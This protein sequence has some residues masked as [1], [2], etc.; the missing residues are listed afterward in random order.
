MISKVTILTVYCAIKVMLKSWRLTFRSDSYTKATTSKSHC[1]FEST[2][3]S[4]LNLY[5]CNRSAYELYIASTSSQS[6]KTTE[7]D[8][9][10]AKTATKTGSQV[11]SAGVK[12]DTG[13]KAADPT[14]GARTKSGTDGITNRN[15]PEYTEELCRQFK[16]TLCHENVTVHFV[17]AW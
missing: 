4:C 16:R 7:S 8:T 13:A 3:P 10:K 5:F 9:A 15:D 11:E 17:G 6:R 1:Q 12:A 2:Q 14:T